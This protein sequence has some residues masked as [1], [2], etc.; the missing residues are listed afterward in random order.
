MAS[1]SLSLSKTSV[2]LGGVLDLTYRFQVA[3]DAKIS[4]DYWCSST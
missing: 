3:P 2:A 1:V 4:G